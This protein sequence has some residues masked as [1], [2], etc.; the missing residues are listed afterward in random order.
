MSVVAASIWAYAGVSMREDEAGW[1]DPSR[2][3]DLR[4]RGWGYLAPLLGDG[5]TEQNRDRMDALVREARRNGLGVV[6]WFTPRPTHGSAIADTV[7]MAWEAVQRY[8]LD[9]VRYQTEAEFEYSNSAE[10]GSPVQ[11]FDAMAVLGMEHRALMPKLPTAVYARVGLNLADAWW[12]KA[13]QYQFRCA[14]ECYG[15]AEGGPHP[16]WAA[17]AAPGSALPPLVGGWWYR[18]RL[19]ARIYMGRLGDDGRAVV[20]E[21]QG[22]FNVGSSAGPRQILQYGDPKWGAVLNFFPGSWLKIVVPS[23]A[24]AAGQKPLGTVLAREIREW[25]RLVKKYGQATKGYSVYVGPEM[26]T[27]QFDAISPNVLT[28]AAL[29]PT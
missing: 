7:Q 11:R 15:P 13:W 6:G 12:A 19:G 27:G 5:V 22:T 16:G 26:T 4:R 24:G 8:G 21:G 10:G 29:L 9:G 14:V 1:A 23:Y 18:V 17:T 2:V 20:V 25:Q 28:G 3:A